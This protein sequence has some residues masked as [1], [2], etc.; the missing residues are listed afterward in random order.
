MS[1]FV[2]KI[3]YPELR[4]FNGKLYTLY[5]Y[6]MVGFV[7]KLNVQNCGNSTGNCV[8]YLHGMSEFAEKLN[9]QNCV[10]ST[11]NCVHYFCTK[12]LDL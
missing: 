1:G 8:Q 4:K 3:E 10:N 5:I 7:E 12:C 2:E 6:G 11:E 9:V